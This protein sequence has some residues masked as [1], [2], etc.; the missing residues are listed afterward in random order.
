MKLESQKAS[1]DHSRFNEHYQKHLQYKQQMKRYVKKKVAADSTF[2]PPVMMNNKSKVGKSV[3]FKKKSKRN[4]TL[5]SAQGSLQHD[6]TEDDR[7][8]EST[9]VERQVEP[10]QTQDLLE[11]VKVELKKEEENSREKETLG[12]KIRP[13]QSQAPLQVD[14][15]DSD[16]PPSKRSNLALKKVTKLKKRPKKEP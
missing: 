3:E 6:A 8:E 12:E 4:K 15:I 1:I 5:F 10:Q 16:V 14:T 7:R 9:L 11:N 2:L 13:S